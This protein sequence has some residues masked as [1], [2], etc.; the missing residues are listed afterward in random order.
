MQPLG[1]PK[2]GRQPCYS[3]R[4][5]QSWSRG[6]VPEPQGPPTSLDAL[7]SSANRNIQIQQPCFHYCSLPACLPPIF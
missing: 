4:G 3:Q 7:I 6:Q 2:Y 1:N 5:G